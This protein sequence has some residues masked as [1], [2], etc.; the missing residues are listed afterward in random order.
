M[1]TFKK[2]ERLIKIIAN[3]QFAIILWYYQPVLS[4]SSSSGQLIIDIDFESG[5]VSTLVVFINKPNVI[6]EINDN[7]RNDINNFLIFTPPNI[8]RRW[9]YHLK[10][11]WSKS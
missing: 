7:D 5:F 2:I 11:Y 4:L 6:A 1:H 10:K 9:F 8:E 3:I